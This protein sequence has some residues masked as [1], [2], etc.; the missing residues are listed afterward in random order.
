MQKPSDQWKKLRRSTLERARRKTVEPLEALYLAHL[1]VSVMYLAGFLWLSMTE[2]P[3]QF[4]IWASA[5]ILLI[6]FAGIF[7][8]ILFGSVL[9]LR[10]TDW[11]IERLLAE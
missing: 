3:Q 2:G 11:R 5:S 8:P 4:T 1:A 10:I 6:S 7:V 9:V